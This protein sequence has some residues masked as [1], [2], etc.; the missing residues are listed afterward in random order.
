MKQHNN[1]AHLPTT[2]GI[3]IFLSLLQYFMLVKVVAAAD[4]RST[5]DMI[6]AS[7]V[8]IL[9]MRGY[10]ATDH[11]MT[12][13][14]GYI[15][16]MIRATNPLIGVARTRKKDPLLCIHG[17][18]VSSK[19]FVVN[20]VDARPK[21]Y[22]R[23]NAASLGSR[24]LGIL[25]KD[26]PAANSIVFLALNFGHDVW[27][28]NQRG[29]RRS[30]G[31]RDREKQALIPSYKRDVSA[32]S[33]SIDNNNNNDSEEA[34]LS[35][36]INLLSEELN[37]MI[38][39]GGTSTN[40]TTSVNN[41]TNST[42]TTIRARKHS[43]FLFNFHGSSRN[44][45]N[46]RYWNYSLDEQIKYDVPL[47]IDFV[48]EKTNKSQVALVTHS[49]GGSLALMALAAKPELARKSKYSTSKYNLQF[50]NPLNLLI[51]V[52]SSLKSPKKV[53][54]NILWAPA[55][56]PTSV[57]EIFYSY[58]TGPFLEAKIGATPTPTVATILQSLFAK[59]CRS[60][61]AQLTYCTT[62]L[63]TWYGF[64]ANQMLVVSIFTFFRVDK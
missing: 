37:S 29:T 14:D 42:S 57:T 10:I 33:G 53:S 5:N 35:S 38:E 17:I 18:T 16:N 56:Y 46:P 45:L 36:D 24:N 7:T 15:I 30:M 12:T 25:L 28:M 8:D 13:P 58:I 4:D 60:E 6:F 55:L 44:R 40:A 63:N 3:L 22:S 47:A 59:S 2:Y 51:N 21:N 50:T 54:K 48:L 23:L 27:L 61:F 64:S 31:H 32:A 49:Q 43:T 26:D 19:V 9:R 41:N 20:S 1:K 11:F 39:N 34:E 52:Y 62:L